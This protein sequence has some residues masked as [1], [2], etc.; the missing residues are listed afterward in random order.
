M[1]ILARGCPF[2]VLAGDLTDGG[3]Q[4]RVLVLPLDWSSPMKLFAVITA[5][6]LCAGLI[7]WA[8]YDPDDL[9]HKTIGYSQQEINNSWKHVEEVEAQVL[10]HPVN[11]TKAQADARDLAYQIEAIEGL[12]GKKT[13]EAYRICHT[14]TP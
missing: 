13:A 9:R 6:I 10:G 7:G 2:F 8:V 3:I 5:A 14:S 4:R 11:E 1:G 12:Y